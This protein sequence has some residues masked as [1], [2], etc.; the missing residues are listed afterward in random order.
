MC[1]LS[2]ILEYEKVRIMQEFIGEVVLNFVQTFIWQLTTAVIVTKNKLGGAY[3][4]RISGVVLP[5]C[6][7][8]TVCC[9]S[10]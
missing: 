8:G 6:C 4:I 3:G 5:V 10:P 9:E 2:Q 7:R 1:Q